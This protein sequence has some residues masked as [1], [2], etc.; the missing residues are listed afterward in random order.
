MLTRTS[1]LERILAGFDVDLPATL[2]R[3]L[4]SVQFSSKDRAR[5]LQLS[6]KAQRG[7][8]TA[9]QRDEL[10]DLLT[11]NDVLAILQA[12]ARTALSRKSS[13]G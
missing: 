6:E 13:A 8:L 3:K 5:Y 9:K 2:A 1:A 10:D 7:T 12:K 11:A 4:L